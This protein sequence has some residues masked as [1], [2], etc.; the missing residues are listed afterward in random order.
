MRTNVAGDVAIVGNKDWNSG[1][2]QGF[3]FSFKY[4]SGPE[5]KVN[6]GDGLSR[7]DINTGGTIADG[8]WHTLSV[9]FDRDGYMKM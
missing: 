6:I 3:V 1:L 9:S 2:N 7:V 5:W 8:Q 4:P